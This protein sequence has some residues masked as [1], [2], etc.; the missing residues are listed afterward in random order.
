M[1]N[2]LKELRAAYLSLPG[3]GQRFI[4]WCLAF[5]LGWTV[6]TIAGVV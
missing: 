6:A 2:A 3:W 1:R 4:E 5:G